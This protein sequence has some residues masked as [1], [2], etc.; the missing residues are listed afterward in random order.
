MC[1]AKWFAGSQWQ[2][3]HHHL[4]LLLLLAAAA[5][6]ALHWGSYPAPLEEE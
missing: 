5:L 1:H 3:H 6:E 4:Q 2:L